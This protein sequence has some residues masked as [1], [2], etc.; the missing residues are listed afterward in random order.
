MYS[1]GFKPQK[2]LNNTS[3]SI[4]TTW[5]I[6]STLANKLIANDL[7]LLKGDLGSGKTTFMKGLTYA[8]NKTPVESVQSPTYT[9]LNIYSGTP[10][11]YHFDLYRIDSPKKFQTLGFDE[12]LFSEGICCIE[13]PERVPH[14]AILPHWEVQLSHINETSRLISYKKI[15]QD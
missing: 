14:L 12:H 13:W 4:E 6:A 7:V 8:L 11:L 5:Q 10:T 2:M 15:N 3:D 9:Y 1:V